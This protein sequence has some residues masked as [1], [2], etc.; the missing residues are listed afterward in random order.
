MEKLH[1]LTFKEDYIPTSTEEWFL[2]A[3]DGFSSSS[4]GAPNLNRAYILPKHQWSQLIMYL[5]INNQSSL[6]QHLELGPIQTFI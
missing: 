3:F 2:Y 4:L 5:K 6:L 1:Y